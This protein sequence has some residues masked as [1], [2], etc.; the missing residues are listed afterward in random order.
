MNNNLRDKEYQAAK[1]LR[2]ESLST[3]F[4]ISIVFFLTPSCVVSN[5]TNK[6]SGTTDADISYETNAKMQVKGK[7]RSN[8]IYGL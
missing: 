6:M 3:P 7:F 5:T 2:K 8:L 4:T 1:L